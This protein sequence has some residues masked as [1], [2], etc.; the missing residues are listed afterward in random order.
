MIQIEELSQFLNQFQ[1]I[2]QKT[3]E[4]IVSAQALQNFLLKFD[5]LYQ[6]QIESN[7]QAKQEKHKNSSANQ[8]K[9]ADLQ[10]FFNE[11][12]RTYQQA[13]STGFMMNLWQF[14]DLGRSEVNHCAVLSWLLRE[15]ADH[16]LGKHFLLEIFKESQ[17][18][19][20]ILNILQHEHYSVQPELC[21]YG[22]ISE[23]IDIVIESRQTC[24]F[25]EAKIDAIEN[26]NTASTQLQ[27]YYQK[28]LNQKHQPYENKK[29]IFL[30]LNKSLP[31]DETL[32]DKVV[33]LSWKDIAKGIKR[34]C[35]N[36][37]FASDYQRIIFLQLARQ[38]ETL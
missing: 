32:H 29:L 19:S 13:F 7:Q 27:R 31:K 33:L 24:L 26:I 15:T 30:T 22:E 1:K 10:L 4:H 5:A 38:F 28:L 23:R 34:L 21:I 36:Y 37:P 11:F 20:N 8:I 18:L 2:S 25:I 35:R 9:P 14:V 16:G 6:K 12:D 3:Q 17:E